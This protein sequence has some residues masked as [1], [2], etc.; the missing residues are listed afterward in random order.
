MI[1]MT[2]ESKSLEDRIKT[3]YLNYEKEQL[4]WIVKVIEEDVS[5]G[6]EFEILTKMAKQFIQELVKLF[7]S[8]LEQVRLS[9][10]S[11]WTEFVHKIQTELKEN[12]RLIAKLKQMYEDLI[13][14]EYS[15]A[16]DWDKELKEES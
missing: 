15:G 7:E 12:D 10:A 11:K 4:A 3:I 5:T 2:I 6:E 16:V 9:E 8:E 14:A 1:T 13:V